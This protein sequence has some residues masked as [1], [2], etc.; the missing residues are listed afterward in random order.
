MSVY[1]RGQIYHYEFR[2]RG[3]RF[4]GST[5]CTKKREAQDVEAE[6][7]RLAKKGRSLR[8][9]LTLNEATERY[10][11]EV[12]AHQ[13]SANT[14]DYQLENLN[15]LIGAQ[16]RLAAIGDAE[17]STYASVRRGER[18]RRAPK[19]HTKSCRCDRCALSPGT[20]NREIELLRRVFRRADKAWKVN[21]GE[22]PEWGAHL[23][24]EPEERVRE[25]TAEEEK[26]LFDHLRPDYWPLFGFA[27]IT[28]IRLG[29]LIRLKKSQVDWSAMVV[30]IRGKSKKPGGKTIVIPIT[31]EAAAILRG[32][33]NDHPIFVFTY[34][35]RR[36]RQKRRKGERYPFSA[37]GWRKPFN[38][39]K[40][41]AGIEDFRF[42]DGRHTAATRVLRACGNLKVVMALL[43]HSD[44]ATTAKYAH[45]MVDDI[46]AAMEQVPTKTPTIYDQKRE[47]A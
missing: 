15:R 26:A 3:V 18:S 16:N 29:N 32:V 35:C 34:E 20:V 21:V 43:G 46:R 39:A 37:S 23:L 28:G 22:M 19:S 7:K 5:G 6:K 24:A 10:F 13:P 17:I 1:L 42:H 9:E 14:T 45:V 31:T 47:K 25:L 36:N 4:R 41:A 11:Q 30:R 44:I 38:D 40:E 33:W 27:L 2:V 8:D 12:A